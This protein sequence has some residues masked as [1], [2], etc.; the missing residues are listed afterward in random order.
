MEG[1]CGALQVVP[2]DFVQRM[3]QPTALA[4]F[5]GWLMWLNPDGTQFPGASTRSSFMVGAGGH[6]VWIEPALD[7]VVV[8]RWLD[9]AHTPGFMARAT[10]ALAGG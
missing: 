4:S 7:A 8:V 1:R 3:Q 2:A 10:R 9:S 6:C 5:Y